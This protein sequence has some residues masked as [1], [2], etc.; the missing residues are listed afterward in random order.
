MSSEGVV[1]GT[2]RRTHNARGG[3]RVFHVG[4]ARQGWRG[5]SVRVLRRGRILW[6]SSGLTEEP[7]RSPWH[8]HHT[9]AKGFSSSAP[10]W[11]VTQSSPRV[12]DDCHPPPESLTRIRDR[13]TLGGPEVTGTGS[14]SEPGS[15]SQT[16]QTMR[17]GV[18]GGEDP[19]VVD[20]HLFGSHET[21]V[22]E[23]RYSF[24][25]LTVV[26][27]ANALGP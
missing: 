19:T 16:S 6:S 10:T 22:T 12:P 1:S 3:V 9:R 13:T 23:T 20:T 25:I 2:R 18:E 27:I 21:P 8:R 11:N 5:G 7:K 14:E 26:V 17:S 15:H 4:S 24:I